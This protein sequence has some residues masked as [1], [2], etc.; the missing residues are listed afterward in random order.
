MRMGVSSSCDQAHLMA[1]PP[2]KW[3]TERAKA[4]RGAFSGVVRS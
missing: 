1:E 3:V 2:V 4:N